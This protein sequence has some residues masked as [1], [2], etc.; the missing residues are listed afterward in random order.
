MVP[1]GFDADGM[2]LGVQVV[3]PYLH[4]LTTCAATEMIA[5]VAGGCPRPPMAE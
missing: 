3:G 5:E 1:I 2:P 4:D